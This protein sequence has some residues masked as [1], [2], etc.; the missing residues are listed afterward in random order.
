M[1]LVAYKCIFK[2]QSPR[3]AAGYTTIFANGRFEIDLY[4]GVQEFDF[5]NSTRIDGFSPYR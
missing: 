3:I 2:N 4:A 1:R 5:E